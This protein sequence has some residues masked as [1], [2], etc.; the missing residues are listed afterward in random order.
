MSELEF[1]SVVSFDLACEGRA[2]EDDRS[3]GRAINSLPERQAAWPSGRSLGLP[4]STDL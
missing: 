2:K 4:S 3:D 1:V